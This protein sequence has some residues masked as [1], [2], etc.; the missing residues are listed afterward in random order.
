MRLT[1][2]NVDDLLYAALKIRAKKN[3][4]RLNGYLLN[5]LKK[6]LFEEQAIPIRRHNLNQF[7]GAWDEETCAEFDVHLAELAQID[8]LLW[9]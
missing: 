9:K 5:I 1:I 2:H 8:D 4:M 6:E 3:E 7:F